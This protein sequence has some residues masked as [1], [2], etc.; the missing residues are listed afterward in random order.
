MQNRDLVV[1]GE[2]AVAIGGENAT[3]SP[4]TERMQLGGAQRADAGAAVNVDP[5]CHRP[6]DL[7]MPDR[8]CHLEITVDDADDSRMGHGGGVEFSLSYRW[9]PFERRMIGPE[10][11]GQRRASEA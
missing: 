11:R 8:R 4:H 3:H 10:S 7:L 5:L 1:I 2:D 6:Q 9:A